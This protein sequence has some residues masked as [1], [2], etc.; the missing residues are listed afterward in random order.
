MS[1]KS[2]GA[3]HHKHHEAAKKA[4]KIQVNNETHSLNSTSGDTYLSDATDDCLNRMSSKAIE[5]Y[6]SPKKNLNHLISLFSP[7]DQ[8]LRFHIFRENWH[9]FSPHSDARSQK[10]TQSIRKYYN[11][12]QK[13]KE[14]Q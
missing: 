2:Y 8:G 13:R 12:K 3:K 5:E 11:K 14:L 4:K 9:Q 6:M 7:L 10:L 1:K